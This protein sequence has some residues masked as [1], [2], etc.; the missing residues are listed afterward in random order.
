MASVEVGGIV[1]DTIT[2]MPQVP[3]TSQ[4]LYNIFKNSF[5]IGMKRGAKIPD[6]IV[7]ID[8]MATMTSEASCSHKANLCKALVGISSTVQLDTGISIANQVILSVACGWKKISAGSLFQYIFTATWSIMAKEDKPTITLCEVWTAQQW[9]K[10]KQQNELYCFTASEG[11]GCYAGEAELVQKIGTVDSDSSDPVDIIGQWVELRAKESPNSPRTIPVWWGVVSGRAI[12]RTDAGASSIYQCTGLA[13]A[14]R[15]CVLYRWYEEGIYMGGSSW[16]ADPGKV[17]PFNGMTIGDKSGS[18]DKT[19]GATTRQTT[20]MPVHNRAK[21]PHT[22]WNALDAIKIAVAALN[23]Q[24]PY[25]PTWRLSGLTDALDFYP[26]ID[27]DFNNVLDMIKDIASPTSGITFAL[28]VPLTSDNSTNNA[29]KSGAFVDIHIS[30]GLPAIITVDGSSASP[31]LGDIQ[32]LSAE[33][34]KTIDFTPLSVTQWDY[35]SDSSA[36]TDV[37]YVRG[38]QP[39]HVTTVGYDDD[40]WDNDTI[41][42]Y[43]QLTKGWTDAEETAWEAADDDD[44]GRG[45]PSLVH[46]WRRFKLKPGFWGKTFGGSLDSIPFK[47]SLS[48]DESE[49]GAWERNE[50]TDKPTNSETW[51]IERDLPLPNN[52]D[53]TAG[54]V[55]PSSMDFRVPRQRPMLF[56]KDGSSY[57]QE[58]DNFEMTMANDLGYIE[59]GRGHKDGDRIKSLVTTGKML[60]FTIAYQFPHPWRIS[61]RR[62]KASSL[63]FSSSKPTNRPKDLPRAVM[64]HASGEN[65]QRIEIDPYAILKLDGTDP[66]TVG[67]SGLTVYKPGAI[68]QLLELAKLRYANPRISASWTSSGELD[69][70]GTYETQVLITTCTIPLPDRPSISG[71]PVN[72]VIARRKWNFRVGEQSTAYAIEPMLPELGGINSASGGGGGFE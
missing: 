70:T 50:T 18:N 63:F 39:L 43:G 67:A 61:W 34:Q 2:G 27:C 29:N 15:Q 58:H 55:S 14:L 9:G 5:A 22:S 32:F 65:F 31:F 8:T 46:V 26:S 20:N 69:I 71:A 13:E 47:R 41:T 19:I 23:D 62:D 53:Y 33:K 30:T 12:S 6:G 21:S 66:K 60:A 52:V 72:G 10:W 40:E 1:F 4:Q 36:V 17:L 64:I 35:D 56:V 51:R 44:T 38:E 45:D 48:G 37:I 24:Y 16:V 54:E 59:V 3:L 7:R 42:T 11:I 57:T 28:K 49:T 25:G 68:Y